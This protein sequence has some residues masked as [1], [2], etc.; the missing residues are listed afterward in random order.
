M[1][2]DTFIVEAYLQGRQDYNSH[3]L[4]SNITGDGEYAFDKPDPAYREKIGRVLKATQDALRNFKPYNPE[5]FSALFSSWRKLA[6]G[7]NIILSV[8]CPAPY[9]AMVRE[10]EGKEYIIF[11]LI[12]LLGCQPDEG[13]FVSFLRQMLTHEV[14]HICIH[15]DYPVTAPSGYRERLGEIVFNEG[16]A[17]AL[18]VLDGI[19]VYDFSS[20]IREHYQASLQ[21]LKEALAETDPEKQKEYLRASNC[22]PY[23]DKFAAISGKLYILSHLD[24]IYE[25]YRGGPSQLLSDMLG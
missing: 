7:V 5:I 9:D 2:I 15:A 4:F 20:M 3:W 25:I 22:G 6:E 13:R 17:H 16:F 19:G 18:A 11:D 21:K 1:Q 14:S 23:W 8:G 12:R 24:S 10:Y